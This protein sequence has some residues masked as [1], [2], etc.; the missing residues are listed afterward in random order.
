MSRAGRTRTGKAGDDAHSL[1]DALYALADIQ[2]GLHD[3][4][5][6]PMRRLSGDTDLGLVDDVIDAL[7]DP[8]QAPHARRELRDALARVAQAVL[9]ASSAEG[10]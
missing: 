4:Q 3:L 9:D 1:I 5:P 7:L 2:S 10:G 8:E 6:R